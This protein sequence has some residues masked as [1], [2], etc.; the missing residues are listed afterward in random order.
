MI[1]PYKRLLCYLDELEE[2]KKRNPWMTQQ[3]QY[4]IGMALLN[5]HAAL[6][7]IMA[8]Y[9]KEKKKWK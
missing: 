5:L 3:Q 6:G 2:A 4:K 7:K 8:K 1:I 9:R